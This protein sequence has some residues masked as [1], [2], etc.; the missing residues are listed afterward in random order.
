[1]RRASA[2][3]HGQVR[4]GDDIHAKADALSFGLDAKYR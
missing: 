3:E 1:M 2:L 4:T